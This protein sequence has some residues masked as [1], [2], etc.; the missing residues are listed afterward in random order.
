MR[1]EQQVERMRKRMINDLHKNDISFTEL[2]CD[3]CDLKYRCRELYDLYN[4]DGD[5]LAIK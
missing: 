5:C 2:T 1:T 3:D 4:T